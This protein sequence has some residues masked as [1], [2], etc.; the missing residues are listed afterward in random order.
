MNMPK[1]A[2]CHHCMRRARSASCA[3]EL[4]WGCACALD[5]AV[6]VAVASVS[7]D[8]PVPTSQSRRGMAFGLIGKCPPV[9]TPIRL[10]FQLEN[11]FHEQP[12]FSW[13]CGRERLL[14]FPHQIF[15]FTDFGI[16]AVGVG[17]GVEG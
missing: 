11:A 3:G 12:L 9:V 14:E 13:L 5:A 17:F 7:N 2:S 6:L 8:A 10:L 1:R 15:P 4:C 16:G